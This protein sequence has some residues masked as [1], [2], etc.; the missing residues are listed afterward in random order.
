[1]CL[2]AGLVNRL[3]IHD[4]AATLKK[5]ISSA[6][7]AGAIADRARIEAAVSLMRIFIFC[8]QFSGKTNSCWPVIWRDE[9]SH[10]IHVY[11]T[12]FVRLFTELASPFDA[13]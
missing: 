5:S 13:H 3:R 6:A 11:V 9:A 1:M 12:D 7:I 4:D 2:H 10:S 8:L